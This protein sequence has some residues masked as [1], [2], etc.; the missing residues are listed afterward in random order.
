MHHPNQSS[1]SPHPLNP[2][3]LN[4]LDHRHNQKSPQNQTKFETRKEHSAKSKKRPHHFEA[5]ANGRYWSAEHKPGKKRSRTKNSDNTSKSSRF[6]PIPDACHPRSPRPIPS[7]PERKSL[8]GDI[9]GP[10]K[11]R[12]KAAQ[13]ILA[14]CIVPD[15]LTVGL[16]HDR[17]FKNSQADNPSSP[18]SV[19]IASNGDED[20]Y[21]FEAVVGT[22]EQIEKDYLRLTSAPK[23]EAVRPPHVLVNALANI[24]TR[25]RDGAAEYDWVCRQLKSVRQ[26]YKV[27]HVKD[28]HVVDVYETHAR[29][30]LEN[31]DLGEFNTCV[32]QVQELYRTLDCPQQV[33]DEFA[34]YRILYNVLVRASLWEQAQIL[35]KLT[36]AERSRPATSFA[37][38]VRRAVAAGNYRHYFK[39]CSNQPPRT[40]V[41]YLLVHLHDRVRFRA[42]TVMTASYGPGQPGT[43]PLGFLLKQMG[44]S[45]T[46]QPPELRRSVLP[47]KVVR[48]EDTDVLQAIRSLTPLQQPVW[49]FEALSFILGTNIACV[50]DRESD[51]AFVDRVRIDFKATKAQ[52]LRERK[53]K[54]ITH[55]GSEDVKLMK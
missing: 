35:G 16:L 21:S 11:P 44:W 40:M 29:I 9:Y 4:H 53:T 25:W 34:C 49:L 5:N 48:S 41:S 12:N 32:A 18:S 10:F 13:R 15:S 19:F 47:E 38:S 14:S 23:P 27:Q 52:G 30:A 17:D 55:A 20:D 37:L 43:V 42:A 2:R 50:P 33:R 28:K 1:T 26:D 36:G 46:D 54:L 45:D 6:A 3:H 39:L 7:P 22:C 51:K 31:N 8:S 24:K